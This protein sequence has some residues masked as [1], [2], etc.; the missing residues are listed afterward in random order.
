[1]NKKPY[2]YFIVFIT[3][4]AIIMTFLVFFLFGV[5]KK[6][7]E[8]FI[9]QKKALGEI[10]FK[11]E[12]SAELEKIH[13]DYKANLKKIE[14]AF[15]EKDTPIEF[16][17]FLEKNA[18]NCFLSINISSL[19]FQ[20]TDLDTG[21]IPWDFLNLQMGLEGTFPDFLKFL[22]KLENSPYLIEVSNLNIRKTQEEKE[23][24]AGIFASLFIKAYTQ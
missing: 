12:N 20:K 1:M 19:S 2:I 5:I 3:L 23:S 6:S 18:S 13:Q 7:S 14:L 21:R 9:S 10:E 24:S 8:D 16:I 11:T 22:E 17:E 15:I 4:G